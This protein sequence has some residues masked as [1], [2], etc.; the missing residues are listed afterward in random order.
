MEEL[1]KVN[2]VKTYQPTFTK[3]D[4][5]TPE[6]QGQIDVILKKFNINWSDVTVIGEEDGGIYVQ[7]VEDALDGKKQNVFKYYLPESKI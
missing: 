7:A 2:E 6:R 4:E 5:C 3:F 1:N